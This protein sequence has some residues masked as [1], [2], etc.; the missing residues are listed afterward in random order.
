M[1]TFYNDRTGE[2]AYVNKDGNIKTYPVKFLDYPAPPSH[3]PKLADL[4]Y[5]NAFLDAAEDVL[6]QAN[7]N[8]K[9]GFV[10]DNARNDGFNGKGFMDGRI[11]VFFVREDHKGQVGFD[12][13]RVTPSDADYR[14]EMDSFDELD[15]WVFRGRDTVISEAVA[16]LKDIDEKP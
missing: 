5:Q 15:T 12:G 10:I 8:A 2:L 13:R 6:K 4:S 11:R 1:E 9:T 3:K 14:F 7:R 16:R